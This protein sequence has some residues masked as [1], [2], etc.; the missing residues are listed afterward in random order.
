MKKLIWTISMSLICGAIITWLFIQVRDFP[1]THVTK[2]ELTKEAEARIMGDCNLDQKKLDNERFLQFM[3]QD[4]EYNRLMNER[5]NAHRE[6][7]AALRKEK[8]K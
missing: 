5:L 2:A 1:A 3:E 7:I 4:K 8:N 6:M